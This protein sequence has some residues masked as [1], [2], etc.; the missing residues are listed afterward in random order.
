MEM[1]HVFPE[2]LG[3]ITVRENLWLAC[4]LCNDCKANRIAA[5][6]PD[7]GGIV[8]LFNPRRQVWTDHFRWTANGERII[9]LTPTGRATVAALRLNRAELVVARRNWV[10]AG[11]HPPKD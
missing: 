5:P 9:G 3:G 7:T 1:D 6:D 10:I 11:W 4:S 8:R 2:S